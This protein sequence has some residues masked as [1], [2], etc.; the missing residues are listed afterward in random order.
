MM[1]NISRAGIT[2]YTDRWGHGI[3]FAHAARKQGLRYFGELMVATASWKPGGI[4]GRP[5]VNMLGQ[6][7]YQARE[8]GMRIHGPPQTLVPCPLDETVIREWLLKPCL[9]MARSGVADG[10][11]IDYESYGFTAFD[12]LGDYLCYCDHC[13]DGFTEARGLEQEV[14]PAD[15]Y[16]WLQAQGLHREYLT[17]LRDR[18]ASVYRDVARQVREIKPDFVFSAYPDIAPGELETCWRTEGAAL[19]LHAPDTPFF[20]IDAS[21]YWPNHNVPWW[22]TS[23]NAIHRLGMRHILGT[24]TGGMF[25]DYPTLDV[26]A[27]QWLYDAA[28][29]HDGNWVWYEHAW[30][31]SDLLTHRLAHRRL[32]AVEARVG[33]FLLQGRED[34][35]FATIVEQS[36]DPQLD[37]HVLARSY[38]L[39]DRHLVRVC[40]ANTDIPVEVRVRFPRLSAETAWTAADVMSG[41]WFANADGAATWTAAQLTEGLVLVMDKR[42]DVWLLLSPG[43]AESAPDPVSTVSGAATAGHKDRPAA[44]APL[45]SGAATDAV[46]PLVYAKVNP[47]EYFGGSGPSINPVLGSSI[48][49]VDAVG[50]AEARLFGIDANAWSPALSPDRARVAFSCY[51]NGQGQIYVMNADGSNVVNISNNAFCDAAPEWSPDG[52]RIAFV[53]DRGG[54]WDICVMNADGSAQRRLSTS[55]GIERSP[56]WSPDGSTLAFE[57]DRNG[58]FDIFLINAE[59]GNER[60]LLSRSR[61]E[62]QPI[63]SPDGR[64]LACTVGMYGNRRDVMVVDAETGACEHPKALTHAAKGWWQF[65][66]VTSIAWSPDGTRI[67]GAY[68][69]RLESGVFVITVDGK[70][71]TELVAREPLKIYPGGD[72]P[73]YQ[74]VGGWYFNGSASRR[75]LLHAFRD[76]HW[77]P[78]GATIAFTTDM[79]PSGYFF[80]HTIPAA[81]G[82]LTRLDA[83]LSPAGKNNKPIPIRAATGE[84]KTYGFADTPPEEGRYFDGSA[85]AKLVKGL[86]ELAPLPVDGWRFKDDAAGVGATAPTPWYATD[87]V[88]AELPSLRLDKFWD[89]Q[90]YK[91]LAEGWYRQRWTCPELP[92][93]KRVFLHIGAVDESVWLYVD[94]HLA[95]W[96]DAADPGATWDKPLLLEVSGNLRAGN[97]HMLVFCVKNIA[98]AGGIWKPVSLRAEK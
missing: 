59:G 81:G 75:W 77:S 88:D 31:P 4:A 14:K 56:A 83:T 85:F 27:A 68:E 51:V 65:N 15:R 44:T 1:T 12:K 22:D 82:T 94:G 78:D 76:V 79:D 52:S 45:P 63:W 3:K 16:N 73:R 37:A 10:C 18:I 90:G 48:H 8:A 64:R 7:H 84:K 32:R 30:G 24:W 21:H 86:V 91:G 57:S 69:K 20:V 97:E 93:G 46:F 72:V 6:T 42:S 41:L 95:A 33:E 61:N 54:D 9:D 74:M 92:P 89:D 80:V 71:L 53:S 55:P 98:G 23:R 36:G 62:Y 66:N 35:M 26:S 38:H 70:E 50:G 67:A 29:S 13:F 19:G 47:L 60:A 25:G 5:A 2:V 39:D 11:H 43:T 49:I 17:S 40:N 87:L 58:D 34:H 28:L 96:Y